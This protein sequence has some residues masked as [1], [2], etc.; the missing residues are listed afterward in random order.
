MS[1]TFKERLALAKTSLAPENQQVEPLPAE[2]KTKVSMADLIAAQAKADEP[3]A[4]KAEEPL[5]R[6]IQSFNVATANQAAT[7]GE[8][9]SGH[10]DA[11]AVRII[12]SK[13]Q[14][15][16]GFEGAALAGEMKLLQKMLLDNPSA[17]HYLIDEDL[18]LA[19][20]AM[21]R[22]TDNRVA[23]DL[24]AAKPRGGKAAAQKAIDYTAPLSADAI[25]AG[26][27]DL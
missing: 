5:G 6:V 24:G 27:A 20:R 7:E 10:E 23:K 11:E 13:I 21:R 16:A 14:Q 26:L 15:L 9:L 8:L 2:P 3:P 19:V 4:P 1:L 17:C 18:G 22:M 12:Q 25:A